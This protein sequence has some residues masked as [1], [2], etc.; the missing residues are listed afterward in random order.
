MSMY[1]P[2]RF[3]VDILC[4]ACAQSVWFAILFDVYDHS[5]VITGSDN[6]QTNREQEL[7]GK[8][9]REF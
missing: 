6:V 8:P 3:V 1:I 2:I 4:R 5:R 9:S 7:V